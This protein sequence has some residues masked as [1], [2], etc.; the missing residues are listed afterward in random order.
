[1]KIG[2]LDVDGH[3]FPNLALM[4]I[5]A[6]HKQQNDQVNFL[7]PM[8]HYDKVYASKVFDFTPDYDF[9][10]LS[11]WVEHGGTG[12]DLQNRL[13]EHIES[14]Y[15]DYSLYGIKNTAYGFLTRGCPRDCSF[16]IVSKKERRWS[17]KVADL[18]QFWQ[19]QKEI[20]LLDPNILACREHENLLEQ[21]I[22]SKAWIDITQGLDARLLTDRNTEL[23]SKLKVKMLHF[24]WDGEK[25]SLLIL[26]KL[27]E[28]KEATNIGFRKLRVYVLVNYDT[29]FEFD[30]ERVYTLKDMGY[31][32]YIMIYNK[33][34]LPRGHKLKKL[35]RWV[36]NKFVF[37]SCERFEDY[38][39]GSE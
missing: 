18:D 21:L 26:R 20:V 19:G 6:Y 24:A 32:P 29:D 30:L 12:Y 22:D 10:I 28:F 4:K 11:F 39:K 7:N 38:M 23:I 37:R 34:S 13:P 16:C 3:N 14:I 8:E 36:N 35:A 15:P 2:L 9:N 27:K 25:D 17:Y 5:S 33:D 1:V 31:D